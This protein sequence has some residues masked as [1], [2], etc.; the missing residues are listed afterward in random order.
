MNTNTFNLF[1]GMKSD[2]GTC[3]KNNERLVVSDTPHSVRLMLF[4]FLWSVF[5]AVQAD[6]LLPAHPNIIM[7]NWVG[8]YTVCYQRYSVN[9]VIQRTSNPVSSHDLRN[10]Q[11]IKFLY[12]LGTKKM[13]RYN[14]FCS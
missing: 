8:K 5:H 2:T 14:L 6:P 13:A 4:L 10:N 7:Y 1:N 3:L 11:Y 9:G 12:K